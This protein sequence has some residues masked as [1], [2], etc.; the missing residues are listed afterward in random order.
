MDSETV[1]V[2]LQGQ[3]STTGFKRRMGT[4]PINVV[5]MQ[6]ELLNRV[7]SVDTTLEPGARE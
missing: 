5:Q 7:G 1:E 6:P 3:I 4:R 2:E